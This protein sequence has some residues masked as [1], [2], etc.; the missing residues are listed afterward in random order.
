MRF[1]LPLLLKAVDHVKK[2][3]VI[4]YPTESVWGLGCDPMNQQA[5][6]K[7]LALKQRDWRKG[8]ILISGH[9]AHFD[10]LLDAE[11]TRGGVRLTADARAKIMSTWP[12]PTTWLIPLPKTT[13]YSPLVYGQ[14]ASIAARVT[15]HPMVVE[16]TRHLQGPIISTSANRAGQPALK[17]RLQILKCFGD[18]VYC[19]PG[20][21][22]GFDRPSDIFDA[23]TGRQLR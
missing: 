20:D 13:A 11:Q 19:L 3:G 4:A 1:A 16:L 2:G 22:L 18:Q 21:T 23:V 5:L 9:A 7:L 12:G 15:T 6:E 17:G 10:D 8:L 14:H